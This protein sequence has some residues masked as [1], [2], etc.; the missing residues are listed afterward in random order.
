M[1]GVR[2]MA[3]FA[4][5]LVLSTVSSIS[6]YAQDWVRSNLSADA[7]RGFVAAK[8]A[9][10]S[11][12]YIIRAP[13][14]GGLTVGKF[15][16]RIRGAYVP[17]GGKENP[18]SAF[19]LFVGQAEWKKYERTA[20]FPENAIVGGSEADGTPLYIIR[21]NIGALQVPGKF[22]K[23]HRTAYVPWNGKEEAV[24]SF[25]ILVR[26]VRTGG[27][28]PAGPGIAGPGAAS[29]G[30]EGWVDA[31]VSD[32]A[33]R[34][35]PAGKSPDGTP[36]FLIRA[37]FQGSLIPGKFN[38]KAK[39]A[40]VPWGGK[41]NPVKN[42]ELYIG[43]QLWLTP[44][45]RNALTANAVV[46]GKEADGTP[47]YAIRAPSGAALVPGKFNPKTKEAYISIGGKEVK[48]DNFE[49]L[50]RDSTAPAAPAPTVVIPAPIVTISS[51]S[52]DPLVWLPMD[53]R[54]PPPRSVAF[55]ATD[56]Y[57]LY[58]I[59]GSLEGRPAVGYLDP[60]SMQA[61]LLGE[62]GPVPATA[63]EVWGGG[64]WWAEVDSYSIPNG[65]LSAGTPGAGRQV[66]LVRVRSGNKVL[67]AFYS[68]ADGTIIAYVEGRRTEFRKGEVLMPDW[69]YQPFSVDETIRLSILDRQGRLLA[70]YRMANGG[71]WSVGKY[72]VDNSI[73][74]ISSGGREI[75]FRDYLG[76]VF[77]GTGVWIRPVRASAPDNAIPTGRDSTGA[78]TYSIR[79]T[80]MDDFVLGQYNERLGIATIPYDG[81]EVKIT[82]FEVLCYPPPTA[83]PVPLLGSN[84][85]A[86]AELAWGTW[87]SAKIGLPFVRP[88]Q[89][90]ARP[91]VPAAGY[92]SGTADSSRNAG[93]GDY[94][95][96][97]VFT[98]DGTTN[99][100]I[101]LSLESKEATPGFYL[102]APSGKWIYH[103]PM[104]GPSKEDYI[105]G[106]YTATTTIPETGTYS[107][108]VN[109]R[110]LDSF[111]LRF[112]GKGQS[113]VLDA[114]SQVSIPFEVTENATYS[115]Y[116]V[117]DGFSPEIELVDAAT[118]A[119]L[120]AS[121]E[122][123]GEG[124][125]TR[126]AMYL[127]AGRTVLIIVRTVQ[128]NAAPGARFL[129]NARF[130]FLGA[131]S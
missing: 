114:K 28:F 65:A 111:I 115:F 68:E 27:P 119:V 37:L 106:S 50:V 109:H 57:S 3:L 15:S 71:Q 125:E 87:P 84:Q 56:R 98:Y 47:L 16:P 52:P 34:A 113:G 72:D 129:L 58:L 81:K 99:E 51:P 64:G 6:T 8:E 41:E 30:T 12:V 69:A 112:E 126:T 90:K 36:S 55:A 74:Y 61:F 14:E 60:T 130:A 45:S 63:Y 131:G 4:A 121:F 123:S 124:R 95:K 110:E 85:E 101:T 43:P 73:G 83:P 42:F 96:V 29:P 94:G 80:Y 79:T 2:S 40:Y 13:F 48:V 108:L 54:F 46:A 78:A 21:G 1:H 75:E 120:A 102:I 89:A 62:N 9:D 88:S 7:S 122:L 117:A 24:E 91:I 23:N 35:R 86:A 127:R 19:E 93:V 116:V 26:P 5:A 18:V 11:P 25:E 105:S 100:T 76:E 103:D 20:A 82:D 104:L 38:P 77:I 70:P 97:Q 53:A 33:A 49:F 32:S 118:K 17:W 66:P 22:N 59:R 10:G 67:P 107:I 39:A 92:W 44:E 128:G 31:D